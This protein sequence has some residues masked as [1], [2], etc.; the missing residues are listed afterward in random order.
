MRNVDD[1]R[2]DRYLQHNEQSTV[3]K[4]KETYW[5]TKQ[6]VKKKLGKKEDEHVVASDAQLDAKLEVFRAIQR[7]CM[8]LLRVIEKYQDRLCGKLVSYC[9]NGRTFHMT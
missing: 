7:S 2:Y 4:L 5:T 9:V 8:E 3:H 1:E 6:Y